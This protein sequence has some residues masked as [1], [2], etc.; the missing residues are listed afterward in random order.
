MIINNFSKNR[1][2]TLVETLIAIAILLTAVVGPISLIGDALHKLYYAKDQMIAIN[3][4]QEG[5]EA[6]RQVR[7]SNMLAGGWDAGISNGYYLV[8]SGIQ[9]APLI[10]TPCDVA[11]VADLKPIYLDSSLGLYRQN[12][13]STATQFSRIVYISSVNAN[14]I[15]ASSTVKWKTGGQAGTVSVSEYLFNWATL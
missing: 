1:G 8:D 2:F 14:E 4:A 5:I 12:T 3:L 9:T 10:S 15:M 11:C 7:D 13:V 6:V